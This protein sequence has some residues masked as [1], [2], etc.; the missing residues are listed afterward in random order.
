MFTGFTEETIRF[1]LG[2]R[3]DNSKAY[4]DAHRQQYADDVRA[5]FYALIDDLADTMLDIDP[6]METRPHKVLSRIN[7]DIRFSKDKSP[8]RD[9]LWFCFRRAGMNKEC[10]PNFWFE[11]GPDHM[12]WGV[13]T[14]FEQKETM[15][16]MRRKMIAHPDDFMDVRKLIMKA[17]LQFGGNSYKRFEVPPGIPEELRAWYMLKDV[18][19]ER[20][21]ADL[22]WAYDRDLSE[23]IRKDYVVLSPFYQLLRGCMEEAMEEIY[24][25]L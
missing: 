24:D 11:Y 22:K 16:V 4:M 25:R 17:G 23:K 21:D 3:F 10:V 12:N 8:Y 20:A 9:H 15:E 18:Y 19:V 7:R 6:D 13:G 1:F 5:P 2:I 14:W